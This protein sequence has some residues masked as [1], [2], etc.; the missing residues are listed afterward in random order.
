MNYYPYMNMMSIPYATMPAKTGFFSNLFKGINFSS[1]L[2][3]TGK[4][5]NIA[6]QAIPLIK[7]AKPVINNAKT[8]FQV[9]NEFKKIDNVNTTQN[10]NTATLQNTNNAQNLNNTTTLQNSNVNSAIKYK[11]DNLPTFFQ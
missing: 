2:N 4:V 10:N 5:L 1:I 8:M 7:Q 3:G 6:N 11:Q 9:M